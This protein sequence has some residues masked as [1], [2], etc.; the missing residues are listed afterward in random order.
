MLNAPTNR[1]PHPANSPTC[2]GRVAAAISPKRK[3]DPS[4]PGNERPHSFTSS[5]I[6][7]ITALAQSSAVHCSLSTVHCPLSAVFQI[8]LD[9]KILPNSCPSLSFGRS[10]PFFF[11]QCK[12]PTAESSPPQSLRSPRRFQ[13]PA[14]CRLLGQTTR[15]G[16]AAGRCR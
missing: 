16:W 13:Q 7:F 15:R 11:A 12:P 1:R 2:P 14:E 9:A 5:L 3:A 10:S 4:N 6:H 8:I